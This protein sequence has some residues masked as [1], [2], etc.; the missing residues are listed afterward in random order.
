[1][2]GTLRWLF[3]C[4]SVVY[5]FVLTHAHLPVAPGTQ[6]FCRKL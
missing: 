6:T 4:V 1:V 2:P 3:E 5:H